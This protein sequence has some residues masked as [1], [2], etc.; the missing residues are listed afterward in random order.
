MVEIG[1]L[2]MSNPKQLE[3]SQAPTPTKEDKEKSK[4]SMWFVG[5]FLALVA[6]VIFVMIGIT[7]N[8]E[9]QITNIDQLFAAVENGDVGEER[10]YV[11]NGYVF[12]KD[13]QNT[14]FTRLQIGENIVQVPLHYGPRDLT[15][16]EDIGRTNDTFNQREFYITFDPNSTQMQYVALAAAEVSL[17]VANGIGGTPVAACQYQDNSSCIDRPIITCENTKDKPVIVLTI[18]ELAPKG[19]IVRAGNCVTLSGDEWGLLKAVDSF[20][21]KWYRIL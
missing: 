5:V 3:P 9:N 1:Q 15:E 2:D 21:L 12:A 6:I 10:G 4:T 11:Y 19:R 13:D 17:N 16:V 20:L 18:D 7:N 8:A 14:W